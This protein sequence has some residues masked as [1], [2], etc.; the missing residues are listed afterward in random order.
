MRRRVGVILLLGTCLGT[1]SGCM[2]SARRADHIRA[3]KYGKVYFI[4][5]AGNLGF[6]RKQNVTDGLRQAGY[7]GDV[8]VFDWTISFN[9]LVDQL[10]LLGSAQAAGRRLARKIEDY[11]KLYPDNNVNIIALSAGT[12]VAIWACEDLRGEVSVENVVLLGSSLSYDYDASKALKHIKDHIFVYYSSQDPILKTVEV[13]G[14]IDGRHGLKTRS[15]GQVGFKPKDTETDQIV[16]IPWSADWE[17]L[18]W[19]GGH[20][21]CTNSAF[22]RFEIAKRILQDQSPSSMRDNQ[23][24]SGQ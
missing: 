19:D 7:R 20:T 14:T 10:N 17:K 2:G 8:E 18:G 9:P 13:V 4:D 3:E 1:V 5:G 12:G 23:V 22:V 21:D 16:N 24:A 15:V 6:N 11:Q